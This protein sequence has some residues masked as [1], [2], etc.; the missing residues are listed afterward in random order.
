MKIVKYGSKTAKMFASGGH[1]HHTRAELR[2]RRGQGAGGNARA[3]GDMDYGAG[4][5]TDSAVL[6]SQYWRPRVERAGAPSVKL[7]QN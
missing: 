5:N 1:R 2:V 3:A 7:R 6:S 4:G